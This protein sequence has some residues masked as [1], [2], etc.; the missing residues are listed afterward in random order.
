M[1]IGGRQVAAADGAT[2]AAVDPAR[3][4][5]TLTTLTASLNTAPKNAPAS[6]PG[7]ALKRAS[8]SAS[9]SIRLPIQS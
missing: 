8:A 3:A 4:K 1:T 5:A 7:L 2:F 6:E 9:M